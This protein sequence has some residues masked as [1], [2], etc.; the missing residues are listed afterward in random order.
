MTVQEMVTAALR[1]ANIID[2]VEG[3]SAAVSAIGLEVFRT[4]VRSMSAEEFMIYFID[5]VSMTLTAG[6][7]DITI[8]SAGDFNTTRPLSIKGGFTRSG[9]RDWP[10]DIIGERKYRKISSKAASGTPAWLWYN[11]EYPLGL[12]YLYPVQTGTPDLHLNVVVPLTDFDELTD[13]ITFPGEY[14]RM[15]IYNLTVELGIEWG[16]ELLPE[17]SA[18]AGKSKRNIEVLNAANRVEPVEIDLISISRNYN[19]DR[20]V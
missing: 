19:I 16:K 13:A 7:G 15:L 11:P 20:D 10:L 6:D 18:I 8:G 5:E 2:P 1:K 4:M 12:I 3:P 17:V 9:G 14:E